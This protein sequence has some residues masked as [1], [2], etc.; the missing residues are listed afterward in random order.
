MSK[1]KPYAITESLELKIDL[2]DYLPS[3]HLCRHIENIVSSLDTTNIEAAYSTKGQN[4]FHPKMMLSI[5]FYGYAVGIRSGR[6]LETACKED[7]AFIYLSK[8]YQPGKTSINEFR[9]AHYLHFEGLF[10]QLLEKCIKAG[11]VDADQDIID[12]S[13]IAANSAMKRTKNRSKY[14]KWLGNLLKDIEQIEQELSELSSLEQEDTS[15]TEQSD[16]LSK[17][18]AAKQHLIS[19]IQGIIEEL[20]D[21]DEKKKLNLTDPDAPIM[22]GKKGYFDTFYNVQ[23]GCD[24]KQLINYCNVVTDQNDKAQLI[25]VLRGITKNTGRK[26]KVALADAGYNTLDA[27]EY[28]Q[29]QGIDGYLAYE[30]MTTD[31]SD[32]PYHKANFKYDEQQDIYTCPAGARLSFYRESF[33]KSNGHTY[34]NYKTDACRNCPFKKECL[35]PSRNR[36]VIK[37]EVRQELRDQMK[38]K[39]STPKGK[40]IYQQ[41]FHPVESIFGQIKYNLGYQQFLLRG[42]HKVKAEFTLMCISHNLRKTIGQLLCFLSLFVSFV[43]RQ[44]QIKIPAWHKNSDGLSM[45][46]VC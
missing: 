25:G 15:S 31:F 13:K 23:I 36:R 34:K 10:K 21:T 41:R 17:A 16:I 42:I 12:G 11:L 40:K 44:Y 43:P 30:D 4:G 38:Q 14:E 32:K 45:N 27:L 5:L 18:Q 35:S 39:L 19:K 22:K 29:Q 20:E 24:K 6:K 2:R 37:R 33:D 28:I 46:F 9:R 26:V 3:D 1:F 8:S 7:L